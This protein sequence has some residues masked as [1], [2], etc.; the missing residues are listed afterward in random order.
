MSDLYLIIYFICVYLLMSMVKK[1]AIRYIII[2][3]I[4][5]IKMNH[6]LGDFMNK[7]RIICVCAAL[8]LTFVLF[9]CDLQGQKVVITNAATPE[10]SSEPASGVFSIGNT[11]D[12]LAE[13]SVNDNGTITYQ[14]FSM[15][16]EYDSPD[17]ILLDG[18]D[19]PQIQITPAAEGI[20]YYYVEVT[21][22]NTK[23]NGNRTTT[24]R[25][26]IAT[27]IV[28]DNANPVKYPVITSHPAGGR[29]MVGKVELSI[30]SD[31]PE[32]GVL[33]Y[34]WYSANTYSNK[35]GAPIQ[36][37]AGIGSS[38][39]VELSTAGT[40]Y[41]YCV[42]TNTL[43]GNTKSVA[44]HPAVFEIVAEMN[45]NATIAIN[46]NVKYQYVRGFGGMD[47]P[48][49]NF[50]A[51]S[52][53]EYEKMYN[54]VTGLGFNM[55][56]IM[57]MPENPYDSTDINLTM[58][59][60]VNGG[61]NRP[62]YYEGVKIVN[63]YNGYVLASP[64]SPPPEWKSNGSKNGG[65]HLLT[66]YYGAYANYLK[67]FCKNMYDNGAPIY[68]VS[69]QNE[70]NFTATYDGCEWTPEEMRDFFKQVGRFTQGVPGYGRGAAIPN[71]LQMNGESA[72]HP[73]INDAAM[74]DAVSRALIDVVGRH[75]YG[76]VQVRYVKALAHPDFPTDRKEVWMTEHNINSGNE[77]AYVNDS[78]WNYVWMMMNDVDVSIRLNDESAF[79][80]WALKRF[81]SFIGEGAYGTTEGVILP[82]GYALSHYAKYA[83]EMWRCGV[84]IQGTL[85]DGKTAISA[86]NVNNA[87]FDRNSTAAKVTTFVSDNGNTIS[88]VLFTPTNTSGQSGV[89]LGTVRINL[90][91][92]FTV[93]TATAVR[94][95]SAIKVKPETVLLSADKKSA[96]I[97]M[98][99]GNIVSV[100]FTK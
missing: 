66:T 77:V 63:K 40:F 15:N 62:N 71:V 23:V 16:A 9:S 51:I 91:S 14:W 75:T 43:E 76:N 42:V 81:Y 29:F 21:N 34:Q 45:P 74:D 87:S 78:T 85:A 30:E 94:S 88:M 80:W 68:A 60:Y 52:L 49:D 72:N 19:W 84:N 55:M 36:G 32:A 7:S 58:D 97:M 65:G 10:F 59:Y 31:V 86:S 20:Y 90:P 2:I 82:R 4:K 41:F 12:L 89:N 8:L 57:I 70:P 100:K 96:Y 11:I 83:S 46:P 24:V 39:E 93:N 3:L 33:S 18:E 28:N 56:R 61:G 69:I 67:A 73:N 38:I 48:W 64:W 25:S 54:P 79:I 44:S 26:G 37:A 17:G 50:F 99:P 27:I 22:T 92:S 53:D 98:P 1:K 35:G 13:A 47:I 95:T 6:F 5:Q